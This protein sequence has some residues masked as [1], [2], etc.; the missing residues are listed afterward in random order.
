MSSKRHIRR[1]SCTGK[2]RHVSA[3]DG[4]RHIAQLHSSKGYQGHMNVYRCAFCRF[5]HVGH[6]G[7]R[8]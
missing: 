4:F 3:D 1:K 2:R 8:R 5:F 6:A 7:A